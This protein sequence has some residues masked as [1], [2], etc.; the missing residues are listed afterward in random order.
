[1]AESSELHQRRQR[2]GHSKTRL[3]HAVVALLPALACFLGGGTQKWAEGIVFT[4]LG[5]Y[6]VVRPPRVSLGLMTNGILAA[7]VLLPL[8]AFLPSHWFFFPVWR[9]AIAEDIGIHLSGLVSPQP[10]ITAGAYVSL[11]GGVCWLYLV[12]TLDL[13][14]RSVRVLLR[15]FVT[16]IVFLAG[17]SILMYW[18]HAAFPFWINPRGFGPFPNRNQTGDLFGITAIVLLACGQDDFRHGRIRWV[19]WVIGL[20]VLTAAIIY[21]FSRAGIGILVGGSTLWIIA[22]ALRQR[23][24]ARIA[25]GVSFLLLLIS[26]ILILGGSTLERFQQWGSAGPG[27]STDFRWK[28]FRDTFQLIRNSPWCGIGLGNF[29][30]VFAFFRKESISELRSLH[31]ESDWLW[32]WTEVGWPAVV[33]TV[34]GAA[35]I[36]WRVLPLQEGTNQRFRLAALIGA[37][38]FAVH[39]LVDVSAHRLGTAMTGIFLLGLALHRPLRLIPSRSTALGFRVLGILLMIAGT[40]WIVQTR[41]KLL[42]PGTVGASNAKL[43]AAIDNRSRNFRETIEVTTRAID[44]APLDWQLY[45]YRGLAEVAVNKTPDA[46]GDFRR[47]RF[48]EPIAYELPVAEGNAWLSSQPILAATAWR[49]ALR[50]AGP[51]R[52]EVFASM[53]TNATLRNPEVGHILQEVGLSQPDLAL[54][55]LGRLQGEP[56][57]QGVDLLLKTDP[58]LDTLGE[59]QKL[60]FFDLWSEHGDLSDLSIQIQRHPEW[61]NYAWLGMAKYKA[62]KSDFHGAYDLTQRFGDAVALPRTSADA[63]LED[64]QKRYSTNPDNYGVGYALYLAQVRQGRIDDALNIARHFSERSNS[65]AYF[66]FLEARCWAAKQNWERAWTAWLAYRKAGKK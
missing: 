56:F 7:F 5:L 47:A 14:L 4:V 12:A 54:S 28:I 27:I 58:K 11:V 60:A 61:L 26:A 2:E 6:L 1:M 18:A 23:S 48:L 37:V 43:L 19:V 65:P 41:S 20:G 3:N 44:W 35:L 22:V 8:L 16:S 50:K 17:I 21:N 59:T 52:P 63:S 64:L 40:S 51:H 25:L 42:A 53:L 30:S 66:H 34:I 13:E 46:L 57:R 32:L 10:W 33:L 36:I 31:P 39:G 45:F 15:L 24:S 29:D 55:Y 49:D 9:T 62:S 38:V